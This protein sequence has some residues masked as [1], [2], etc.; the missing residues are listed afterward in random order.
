LS[1]ELIDSG[2]IYVREHDDDQELEHLWFL[3]CLKPLLYSNLGGSPFAVV[4]CFLEWH[5]LPSPYWAMAITLA[6]TDSHQIMIYNSIPKC[7]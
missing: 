5:F 7:T 1:L 4:F 3:C 6:G 2:R